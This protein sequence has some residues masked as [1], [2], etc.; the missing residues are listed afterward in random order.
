MICYYTLEGTFDFKERRIRKYYAAV[1]SLK[2]KWGC[3]ELSTVEML[4]YAEKKKV[5]VYGWLK[6]IPTSQKVRLAGKNI[7]PYTLK[8][9]ESSLLAVT[10]MSVI[11]LKEEFKFSNPMV[12]RF[13]DQ[14]KN[15]IDS[16][17][18]KQ[19]KC[20]YYYL[21]DNMILEWFKSELLM[22]LDT[23]EKIKEG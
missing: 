13:L 6:S 20:K 3:D 17:S 11:V 19:P 12:R 2:E 5:D 9:V 10:L 4:N 23:G 18:R 22:D 1:D 8:F 14:V 7:T 21:D 15:Y 16:Y